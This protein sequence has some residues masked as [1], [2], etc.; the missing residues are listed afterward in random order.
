MLYLE[1]VE[2]LDVYFCYCQAE[3]NNIRIMFP[4]F[5][6]VADPNLNS[7]F[8]VHTLL[9]CVGSQYIQFVQKP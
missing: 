8:N 3:T 6:W 1:I 9:L 4:E 2:V 5:S 7:D